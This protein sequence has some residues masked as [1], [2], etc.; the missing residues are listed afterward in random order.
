MSSKILHS[1]DTLQP[2]IKCGILEMSLKIKTFQSKHNRNNAEWK[3]NA[4]SALYSM[5]GKVYIWL[6][7]SLLCGFEKKIPRKSS[8]VKTRKVIQMLTTGNEVDLT[9]GYIVLFGER[10][11]FSLE[12]FLLLNR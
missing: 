9:F 10:I 2:L 3:Y 5:F 12:C 7:G 11:Y 4:F 8:L 6:W 1:L